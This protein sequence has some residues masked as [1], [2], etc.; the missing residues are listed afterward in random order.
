M[1]LSSYPEVQTLT[2]LLKEKKKKNRVQDHL[3]NC[4]CKKN[5]WEEQVGD[6]TLVGP[7]VQV[8]ELFEG[9]K[10]LIINTVNDEPK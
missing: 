4:L 6:K 5:V 1:Y 3:L 9:P 10:P 8:H 2:K 7:N